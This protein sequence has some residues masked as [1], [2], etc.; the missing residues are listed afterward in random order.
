MTARSTPG[1]VMDTGAR[2]CRIAA[3]RKKVGIAVSSPTTKINAANTAA[4]AANIGMRVGMASRLASDR[5]A[6]VLTGDDQD[7]EHTDRELAELETGTEDHAARIREHL[8]LRGR[9]GGGPLRTVSAVNSAVNPSVTTTSM[10]SDH[11][12]ERRERILVHSDRSR[13]TSSLG[14]AGDRRVSGGHRREAWW[15]SSTRGRCCCGRNRHQVAVSV[16][17]RVGVGARAEVGV[18]VG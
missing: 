4:L 1:S 9:R 18:G 17:V 2:R 8:R 5:A 14:A 12:V 7:A 13:S 11:N 3:P 16:R 15:S 6:G 10:S